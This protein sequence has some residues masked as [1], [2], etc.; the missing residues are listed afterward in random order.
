MPSAGYL[1]VRPMARVVSQ[2]TRSWRLGSTL[3]AVFGS[4]ALVLASIGLY[5]VVAYSVAQRKHEVGV[6]IALGAKAGN[7]VGLVMRD[8]LRVV[9]AGV[10][11]GAGV[12]LAAGQWLSPLLFQVSPRD[13][14]VFGAVTGV[15]VIVA[16]IA[17]GVPALRAT[18]VDPATVLRED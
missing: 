2:V 5:S 9:L 8:G 16:L 7:V 10:A 11:V 4:L 15:L 18:R 6:R 14:W 17:S 13:P 3:F 12:A 1:A